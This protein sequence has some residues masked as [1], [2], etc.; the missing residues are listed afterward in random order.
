M[1]F[2]KDHGTD[3]LLHVSLPQWAICVCWWGSRIPPY[4]HQVR[5]W[6][7]SVLNCPLLLTLEA[8]TRC[9]SDMAALWATFVLRFNWF[10]WPLAINRLLIGQWYVLRKVHLRW[11]SYV[12]SCCWSGHLMLLRHHW[13]DYL[14]K[15]FV[16]LVWLRMCVVVWLCR[17][18]CGNTWWSLVVCVWSLMANVHTVPNYA[19]VQLCTPYQAT[20]LPSLP[21]L[22]S[23]LSLYPHLNLSSPPTS[24]S[25]SCW[26]LQHTP[27]L[28]RVCR[29]GPWDGLQ[30]TLP[31]GEVCVTM[32]TPWGVCDN[33]YT[34][35]CVWQCIRHEVRVTMPTGKGSNR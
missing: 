29:I 2:V 33:A 32:R 34:M 13:S 1:I 6:A 22:P 28:V 27:S 10:V 19:P 8:H 12:S 35:R 17:C 26:G 15:W 20:F 23:P 18:E 4:V 16:A 5:V 14:S 9:G 30:W 25:V 31:W 24:S 11:W 3:T 7:C 21:S